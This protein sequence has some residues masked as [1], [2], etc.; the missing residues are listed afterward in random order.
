MIA[1]SVGLAHELLTRNHTVSFASDREYYDKKILPLL[2]NREGVSL[3]D[4]GDYKFRDN[5]E[6]L[7]KSG[8]KETA[9]MSPYWL[10]SIAVTTLVPIAFGFISLELTNRVRLAYKNIPQGSHPDLI[11]TGSICTHVFALGE[12]SV[13]LPNKQIP[14]VALHPNVWGVFGDN[15]LQRSL[16]GTLVLPHKVKE[17]F[18]LLYFGHLIQI[19]SFFLRNFIF[20]IILNIS[21]VWIGLPPT[22]YNSGEIMSRNIVIST[23]ALGFSL[24]ERIPPTFFQVGSIEVP[25]HLSIAPVD[26]KNALETRHWLDEERNSG[27]RVVYVAFGTEAVPSI[28]LLRKIVWSLREVLVKGVSVLWALR[29]PMS[30]RLKDDEEANSLLKEFSEKNKNNKNNNIG[31]FRVEKFVLQKEVLEHVCVCVF[32]THGGWN[33]M[34]ESLVRPSCCYPFFWR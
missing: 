23:S 8:F 18:S 25:S 32:L 27:R 15:V 17:T 29:D 20:P 10:N 34:V 16:S 2:N 30:S 9:T 28:E 26:D 19:V 14:V 11:V 4:L 33:S 7:E 3:I 6:I 1:P 24:P 13:L 31:N 22:M 12:E 5:M 21:R